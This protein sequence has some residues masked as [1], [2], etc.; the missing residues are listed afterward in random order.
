[1]EAQTIDPNDP[2]EKLVIESVRLGETT[3]TLRRTG[4]PDGVTKD[5]ILDM[6]RKSA[7]LWAEAKRLGKPNVRQENYE[8]L[9]NAILKKAVEDYESMMCGTVSESGDNMSMHLI[10]KFF[11]QQTYVKLNMSELLDHIKN[12]YRERF[13]PY[14]KKHRFDICNQWEDFDKQGLTIEERIKATKHRCP[15][16]KGC[17]RPIHN[18]NYYN[19]G[20]TTC[21]LAVYLTGKEDK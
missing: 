1:M 7:E 3:V 4:L 15:L 5:D 17:L 19:I 6:E 12:V 21:N 14:A 18:D 16:C 8:D 10:E 9:A 13:I 11:K 2:I 20:C